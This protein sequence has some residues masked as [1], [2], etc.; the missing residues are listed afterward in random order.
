MISSWKY[1]DSSKCPLEPVS[2]QA[3]GMLEKWH[4]NN[5]FWPE[6]LKK[7]AAA[8]V[9]YFKNKFKNTYLSPITVESTIVVHYH[10]HRA[11]FSDNLKSGNPEKNI[12]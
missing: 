2:I 1:Q 8:R 12:W 6:F 7:E 10:G 5:C 3:N 11:R 9:S 4:S